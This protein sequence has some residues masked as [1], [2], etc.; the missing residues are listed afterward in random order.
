MY[1]MYLYI[2]FV[3]GRIEKHRIKRFSDLSQSKSKHYYY[4][5]PHVEKGKGKTFL[6]EEIQCFEVSP[7][8]LPDWEKDLENK[9]EI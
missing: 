5:E 1:F 2:F 3:D 6:R 4:E 7:Y 9:G 8:E